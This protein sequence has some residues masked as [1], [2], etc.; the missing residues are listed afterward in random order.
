MI[1]FE[2][3]EIKNFLGYGNS[4]TTFNFING[5]HRLNGKNGVGKS[6][7]VADAIYYNLFGKTFRDIKIDQLINTINKKEMET[8][9]YFK[10]NNIPYRIERGKK[11]DFFRIYKDNIIVPVESS[12]RSYQ[13]ILEED[14]IHL[15]SD[16]FL[17][18]TLK[19]STKDISFCNLKTAERRNVVEIMM[20]TYLYSILNKISKEQID[21][22]TKT[23]QDLD[24]NIQYCSILIRQEEQNLD[25]LR[26][27]KNEQNQKTYQKIEEYQHQISLLKEHNIKVQIGLDKIQE[28]KLKR[29]QLL[30]FA[31]SIQSKISTVNTQKLE[32]ESRIKVAQHKIEYFK[33][34]CPSCPKVK[35]MTDTED[36]SG[37][38][39]NIEELNALLKDYHVQ[40]D[41]YSTGLNKCQEYINRERGL[42]DV[43]DNNN[44]NIKRY[45]KEIQTE[46]SQDIVIDD[47]NLM[48]YK[49]QKTEYEKRYDKICIEKKYILYARNL[50]SDDKIKAYIVKQYLPSI[51]S[52]L[53]F[54]LQKFGSDIIL[55]FDEEF[56]LISKSRHKEKFTFDS[57]SDGQKR[58][59]DLSIMFMWNDFM[60]YK[61]G[62]SKTNLLVLDEISGG[63][64]VENENIFYEIIK[65][66]TVEN[67]LCTI[68]ISHQT[69]VDNS[70]IDHQY[71]VSMKNGFSYIQKEDK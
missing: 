30:E 58:R 26:K 32:L 43:L 62:Q 51:N 29:T 69:G 70:I 23:L 8:Y 40:L 21:K 44:V 42:R 28:Y 33:K 56:D 55:E 37:L 16:I 19:S 7:I 54:Y 31:N 2:K 45:E 13:T 36:I 46:I 63:L 9:L 48:Q 60:C 64:D 24:K 59:I 3:I 53:N 14:I 4:L 38:Q 12:V 17:Q 22:L 57:Y 71:N 25:N 68:F 52:L 6:S 65:S 49:I 20:D 18:T 1:I 66:M 34:M 61:T 47:S 35:S 5:I 27:I 15:T 41:K 39:S 67:N 50:L 11:P 10:I